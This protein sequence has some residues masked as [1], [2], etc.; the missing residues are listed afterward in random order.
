[1]SANLSIINAKM[2]GISGGPP[3]SNPLNHTDLKKMTYLKP[4]LISTS[5]SEPGQSSDFVK[6][7]SGLSVV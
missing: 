5:I 1:M 4:A 6:V 3:E 7:F 2:E